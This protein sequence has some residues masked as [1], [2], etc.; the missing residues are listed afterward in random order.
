MKKKENKSYRF[1]FTHRQR[2][3]Q[4][5]KVVKVTYTTIAEFAQQN[6]SNINNV[7]SDLQNA[8]HP[9]INYTVCLAEDNKTFT[10][11]AFFKTEEDQ[12][13][14]SELSSFKHFQTQL[15]ASG[16]EVQPRQERLTLVGSSKNIF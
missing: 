1:V 9:G 4:E 8:N 11:T 7:M 16:P 12:K 2:D 14:L 6:L 13:T 15:K 5:M 10:H 3:V